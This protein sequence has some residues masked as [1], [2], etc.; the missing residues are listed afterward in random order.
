[1]KEESKCFDCYPKTEHTT[2]HLCAF[3]WYRLHG[4]GHLVEHLV[5]DLWFRRWGRL[6]KGVK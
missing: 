2:Y 3:H 6:P 4:L 1:M 5:K